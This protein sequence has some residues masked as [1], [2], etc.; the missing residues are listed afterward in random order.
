[1]AQDTEKQFEADIEAW[2]ISAEGG[3]TKARDTGYRAPESAGM[4]LDI[5]TLTDFVKRTQPKHWQRFLKQ[6]MGD[7][8]TEFYNRFEDAVTMYGLLYVMQHG[9][10]DRGN[11][12]KV[13]FFKPESTLNEDLTALYEQNTCQCIRQWHYS[14]S[15]NNSVD[16]MFAVNGIPILAVELKNQLCGQS[17]THELLITVPV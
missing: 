4:A 6:T 14:E 13:C 1:M 11:E 2:L 7:P 17:I 15:N 12:F 9:F 5:G 8:E 3:W 10:K 16:M